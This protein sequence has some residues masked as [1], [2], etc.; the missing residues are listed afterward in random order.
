[1]ILSPAKLNISLNVN[2]LLDN[3]YHSIS[4]YVFFLDLFDKLY[5]KKSSF[6]SVIV[7]GLFKDDLINNGG[8]TIINKSISFCKNHYK[9]NQNLIIKLEK[10]IPI[11]AGLGGGS[12][13]SA[14]VIRYFLSKSKSRNIITNETV[15]FSASL[16][17][18][19]PACL[20]SK[21]LL[22]EGRGEKIT[23]I[24]FNNK[25]DIG[26]VLINP[27]IQ[28]STKKVFNNFILKKPIRKKK[29]ILNVKTIRDLCSILRLGNDLAKSAIEIVPEVLNILNLFKENNTCLNYGM[30][31]S[32]ATCYGIFRS[33]KEA[34]DFKKS[35]VKN[36]ETKNYWIWS[37][38]LLKKRNLIL[39]Q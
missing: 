21:P 14:S 24:K 9:M 22:M 36:K 15:Q 5:I 26:V 37:G 23:L 32:G 27:K 38:G 1:M 10:N 35:I 18:D 13:N 3:G 11:S 19:V 20:Y 33:K 12:A 31:G 2:S 16:G 28:L 29:P 17:S 39:A 34:N 6:N 30:S 7:N 4:S 25:L 8:D